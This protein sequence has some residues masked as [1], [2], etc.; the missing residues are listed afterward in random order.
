MNC[1]FTFTNS[2]ATLDATGQIVVV[3]YTGHG[4]RHPG[5]RHRD[6]QE[7]TTVSRLRAST[8]SGATL[9][10][11]GHAA[12]VQLRMTDLRDAFRA[13]RATPVVS[14]VAILSL[15][16]GIGA[17]TAIFSLVNA[18]MLRSAA[19]RGAAA[20]RAGAARARPRTSWSNPLW[21]QLRERDQQLFDG[22]FAYSTQRFNL[23]RGGEAQLVN[24]VMASG[25]FFDV[26]GVPAILGRT[27]TPRQRRPEGSRARTNAAGR[28][29]QLRVLAAAVRRRRRT[30]SAR[31]SS[32]IAIPFTIIGV[33]APSSP[34][35]IRARGTRSSIPLAAEPLMRGAKESAM[36]QRTWWWLR[37]M[38]RLKP[39][40]TIDRATAALRGVQPQ[41]REAT[42][43]AELSRR[44]TCPT[45]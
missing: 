2:K 26:L 43:P 23:A 1:P 30:C 18:L 22:A 19:G 8:R 40:D 6:G 27:F 3:N 45:T 35:S 32:S 14:A 39:G 17:N 25:Q 12:R 34:A 20:A 33:T 16:L 36:D 5:Q 21:E 4:L 10:T 7:V 28:G 29:H 13:L 24:G 41:M 31:R 44:R 11:L 37:V 38:A 42:L 9:P 15:A